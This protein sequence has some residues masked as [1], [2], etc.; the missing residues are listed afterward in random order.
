MNRLV[1]LVRVG[2]CVAAAA[3][4]VASSLAQ[5]AVEPPI[6]VLLRARH[7]GADR[8]TPLRYIGG[9][10]TKTLLYETLVRR[11]ADGRIA[12]GLATRWW[13]DPSGTTCFLELREG[14]QFHDGMPVTAEA[15][16]VHFQRW[17]GLPEHDWLACNRRIEGVTTSGDR[18]V[19]LHLTEPYAIL[20]DLVAINPCAV[21][22]PGARDWEGEFQRP[23]GTGPFRFARVLD[24]GE[25][26]LL[27]RAQPGGV[28]IEI[29]FLP[30]GRDRAPVDA[31]LSD[32]ADVFVGGWEEDLPHDALQELLADGRFVVQ[33]APGSSVA[34]VSFR[35]TEGPTADPAIRR[36]IQASIDRAVLIA[37]VEHGR[38]D[39]TTAWA[40]A[41]VPFWPRSAPPPAPAPAPAGSLPALQIAGG[42]AGS[43]AARIAEA[44]QAQLQRAG[45]P[46]EVVQP[47]AA[48]NE[49]VAASGVTA[50]TP[51]VPAVGTVRPLD[52]ESGEV[53]SA[54]NRARRALADAADL[55]VEITHGVPYDP[56]Q[57]LVAR[58]GPARAAN[59]DQA[60]PRGGVDSRLQQLVALAMATWDETVR[61][62]I[63]A[64]IQALIDSEALIVPLYAPRR[65]AL[66]RKEITG[67]VLPIDAYRVD[68]HA[69]HRT[70]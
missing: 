67:I 69:I 34:Y 35:L 40:A 54:R 6:R 3:V 48:R 10:E 20:D 58:F 21:V 59:A 13:F 43:R 45:F 52:S 61:L 64:E 9:F 23:V 70:P 38:G 29:G 17:V 27:E 50:A 30:R 41:S 28:P 68:L 18:V 32:R 31:L 49:A 11:G 42:A 46:V 65:L 8:L 15:V 51:E 39:A 25:R 4:P 12:P 60:R 24:G 26:W 62:P 14:A 22:G 47:P 16:R 5:A 19:R 44:L 56:H 33:D 2:T 37:A 63:Y 1:S 36:R 66:R 55:R 57:S 7:G 53:R